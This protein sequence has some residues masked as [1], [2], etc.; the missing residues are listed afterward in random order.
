MMEVSNK[1]H[2]IQDIK[3]TYFFVTAMDVCHN[4]LNDKDLAKKVDRLLHYGENYNLI[5][6]SFKESIY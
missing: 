4:H 2:Q 6:D 5:G 3:D 1:N